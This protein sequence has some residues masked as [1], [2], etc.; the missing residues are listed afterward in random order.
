MFLVTQELNLL[1]TI[2]SPEPRFPGHLILLLL[3]AESGDLP[4]PL[5]TMS[6]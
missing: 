2:S 1:N 6:L 5:G 3:A 4:E